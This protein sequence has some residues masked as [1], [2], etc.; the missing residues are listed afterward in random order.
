ME[1]IEK[2]VSQISQEAELE[3]RQFKEKERA[4]MDQ[5]FQAAVQ[6][7]EIE[8]Q[9]RLE[10]SLKQLENNYK[11][12]ANRQQM[13]KKQQLLNRKQAILEEVFEAAVV[14]MEQW[15][16]EKQRA[17]AHQALAQTRLTGELTL[18]AGEKSQGIFTEEWLAEEADSLSYQLV[19]SSETVADQAGFLLDNHGVQYNFLYRSLVGE[20]QQQES[21]QIAQE[22]FE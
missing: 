4:R 11:Q 6:E 15:S 17:F 13:T 3:R 9:Q 18:I 14:E 5:A 16:V 22:I 1:A 2:I 21:F 10:K 20:I 19:L 7:L 8:H 12:V